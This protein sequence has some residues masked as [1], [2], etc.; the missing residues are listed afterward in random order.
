MDDDG[1]EAGD[2]DEGIEE[3]VEVLGRGTT[4][5]ERGGSAAVV[6][7]RGTM[8][9]RGSGRTMVAG[10]VTTTPAIRVVAVT[11]YCGAA[12]AL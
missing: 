9:V 8:T 3:D 10:R 4:T 11:K 1:R 6:G 12:A 5:M 7:R 2:D